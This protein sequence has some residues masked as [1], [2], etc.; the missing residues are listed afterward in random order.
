MP[1]VR[2]R[3]GFWHHGVGADRARIGI[4]GIVEELHPAVPAIFALVGELDLHRVGGGAR[5][6]ALAALILA[7][8]LEVEALG[9]LELEPDRIER[10][11]AREDGLTVG[12]RVADAHLAVR[13]AAA[14]RRAD[15][16]EAQIELGVGDRGAGGSQISRGGPLGGDVGLELFGAHCLRGRQLAAARGNL[17]GVRQRCIGARRLCLRLG[18]RGAIGTGVDREQGRALAHVLSVAEVDRSHHA[19][20]AR[21]D[22]DILRSD[23]AAGIVVPVDHLA[24]DRSRDGHLRRGRGRRCLL[25]T[26]SGKQ[27]KS[28]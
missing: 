6:A 10:H 4:D 24:L 14:E 16:G 2:N 20:D 28:C 21:T 7:Q 12:D 19:V 23:E 1:G 22:L 18:E 17:P 9:T 5:R 26:A 27:Q 13:H 11:D 3:L 8:I 25:S 15:G